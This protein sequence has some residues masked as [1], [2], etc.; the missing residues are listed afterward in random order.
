[1][2]STTE[3]TGDGFVGI[4]VPY[5]A[6]MLSK[7]VGET[8]SN[9]TNV[10]FT[11][12]GGVKP[13]SVSRSDALEPRLEQISS[14]KIPFVLTLHPL[15]YKVRDVISRNFHILQDDPETSAIFTYKRLVCFRRSKNIRDC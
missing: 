14:H 5:G 12:K 6:K 11:R 4:F 9:F 2:V 15:N 8:T 7:P 10:E 13:S 1:M 3:L